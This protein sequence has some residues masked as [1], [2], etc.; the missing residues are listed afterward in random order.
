[1]EAKALTLICS[2]DKPIRVSPRCVAMCALFKSSSEEYAELPID[3]PSDVMQNFVGALA[4][5][6][7]PALIGPALYHISDYCGWVELVPALQRRGYQ[8]V[9]AKCN[10]F[11]ETNKQFLFEFYAANTSI[12]KSRHELKYTVYVPKFKDD[13]LLKKVEDK[14]TWPYALDYIVGVC[15]GVE[16]CG[17]AFDIHKT[18]LKGMVLQLETV[19]YIFSTSQ[20]V[21]VTL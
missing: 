10:Q 15:K 18:T 6:N 4:S 13:L 1:M 11:V 8:L 20:G 2:D 19:I 17:I 12:A 5:Q 16:N 3:F 14:I 7:E 9:I 21:A